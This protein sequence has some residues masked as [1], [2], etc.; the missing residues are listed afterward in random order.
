MTRRSMTTRR[1]MRLTATVALVA[2]GGLLA[3]CGSAKTA[4]RPARIKVTGGASA[5]PAASA[6]GGGV[7]APVAAAASKRAASDGASDASEPSGAAVVGRPFGPIVY[8][9]RGTLPALDGDA[10]AWHYPAKAKIT[11]NQVATLA[12]ALGL[13]GA[14]EV[15]AEDE[16]GG[17]RVGPRDGSGASL[18]VD[19]DAAGS[20]SY[21]GGADLLLAPAGCATPLPVPAT[22]QPAAGTGQ[23]DAPVTKNLL[24]DCP[25]LAPPAAPVGVPTEPDARA[26]AV[27]LAKTLGIDIDPAD[28]ES[29]GDDYAR[30]VAI[31]ARLGGV[32]NPLGM[33]VSYGA[34]GRISYASGSLVAP[35]KADRYPR[36]GTTA[37]VDAVKAGSIGWFGGPVMEAGGTTNTVRAPGIATVA[38]GNAPA[39]EPGATPDESAPELTC[40]AVKSCETPPS[41]PAP[42]P[43]AVQPIEVT[44][45]VVGINA[46]NEALLE[47]FGADGEVWLLPA[48]SLVTDD[49]GLVVPAIDQSYV[50]ILTPNEGGDGSPVTA[51][52][53]KPGV[54]PQPAPAV[55]GPDGASTDAVNGPSNGPST[56]PSTSAG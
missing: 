50:D 26:K 15:V 16:G 55:G 46:A 54:E 42:R 32:R 56:G 52:A 34:E 21:S 29:F 13:T 17:W 27:A 18:T 6:P 24:G 44:P 45:R 30:N 25:T 2:I 14:V 40:E 47:V 5:Q 10:Q 36:I 20:W 11:A 9:V 48:Y 43:S 39:S 19:P 53:G 49:G 12:K 7:V 51:P 33:S 31:Y 28:I 35:V 37:A 1:M 38:G 4:T 8:E 41:T 22:D 23:P 3:A